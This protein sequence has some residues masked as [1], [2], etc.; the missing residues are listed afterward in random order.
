MT[1]GQALKE[2]MKKCGCSAKELAAASGISQ[3]SISRYKNGERAPSRNSKTLEKLAKGLTMLEQNNGIDAD[4]ETVYADLQACADSDGIDTSA[5]VE[6]LNT[7]MNLLAISNGKLA[8]AINYDPSHLSRIRSG[9]RNIT[10]PDDFA[11]Q[12]SDYVVQKYCNPDET[13]S[14]I[15]LTDSD[16]ENLKNDLYK[17]L[18]SG[19]TKKD[20]AVAKLLY[21][22]ES[23]NLD[24]YIRAIHF[25]DIK[26]P[27]LPFTLPTSKMY[28]GRDRM[29][30]CELDFFRTTFLSRSK[31]CVFMCSDMPMATMAKDIEFDKKW[32]MSIA[33]MLKK[34]LEINI[35]HNL[36]RPWDEMMLGLQAWIPIYMTG[37]VHPYYFK[38]I[39]TNIYHHINYVSGA[40]AMSGECVNG[41]FENGKYYLTKSKDEI[42]YYRQKA[43]DLLSKASPLMEI[44]TAD[45][46]NEFDAFIKN[47]ESEESYL[48]EEAQKVFNNIEVRICHGKWVL[49]SKK[50]SPNI[51][52]VIRHLRLMQAIENFSAEI[53]EK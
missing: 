13:E 24:E 14:I 22:L 38:T 3:S 30:Q 33:V 34:G 46:K 31:D 16:G 43:D 9:N 45:R 15:T 53:E 37:Q 18:C 2:H 51:H 21:S 27:T 5:L 44:Y 10:K 1:F 25:N 28:Y 7:L 40:A 49:I 19:Q 48:L 39:K 41:C 35:V 6:N 47:E 17:W 42:A 36:D 23:F 8:Q 29:K 50:S 12:I 20:D 11:R 32:M 52:F 26:V 4:F